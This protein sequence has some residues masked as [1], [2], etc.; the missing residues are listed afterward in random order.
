MAVL[1]YV[2]LPRDN[3]LSM[4]RQLVE[5]RLVACVNIVDRVTSVYRWNGQVATQT[6]SLLLCKTTAEREHAALKFIQQAHP[7]DVPG[8]SSL[9]I[10]H[11][12]DDFLEWIAES[13]RT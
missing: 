3:A 9:E 4:A 11:T 2:T 7:Y 12:N 1:I 5:H 8:I 6:E 10:D 13:V